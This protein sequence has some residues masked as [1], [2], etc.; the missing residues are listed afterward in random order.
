M[1]KRNGKKWYSKK[2]KVGFVGKYLFRGRNKDRSFLLTG[3]NSKGKARSVS[4]ESHEAAKRD[5]A[6][7]WKLR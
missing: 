4:Y 7:N 3:K 2:F 6:H 1:S 5:P